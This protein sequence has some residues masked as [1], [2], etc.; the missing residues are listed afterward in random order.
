VQGFDADLVQAGNRPSP[1]IAQRAGAGVGLR[2]G[3][4]LAV[5]LAGQ[6][7]LVLSLSSAPTDVSAESFGVSAPLT[8]KA[9]PGS[10]WNTAVSAGL[11]A[12]SWAQAARARN[13]SGMV[14]SHVRPSKRLPSSLRASVALMA[15]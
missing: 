3:R 10:V 12:Q 14:P 1:L 6:H 7:Q 13:I 4:K 2:A 15:L 9:A 8:T 11:L 5:E